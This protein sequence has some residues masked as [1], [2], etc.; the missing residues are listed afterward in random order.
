MPFEG[1]KREEL[2]DYF[3]TLTSAS[4]VLFI[5]RARFSL[6]TAIWEGG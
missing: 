6:Y 4:K 1:L 5:L 2:V 3:Y